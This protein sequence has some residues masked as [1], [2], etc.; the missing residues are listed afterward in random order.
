MTRPTMMALAFAAAVARWRRRR[1]ALTYSSWVSPQ[2]HLSVWQAN[3][4]AE[5]EKATGDASSS[6]AAEAS[7]G[8]ARNLRRRA[9]RAHGPFL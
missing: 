2:H 4:T 7:L 1:P 9:R 8:A 5:V 6:G 3:W